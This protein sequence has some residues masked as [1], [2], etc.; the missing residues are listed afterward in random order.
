MQIFW[1][2]STGSKPLPVMT[3]SETRS[4]PFLT[5]GERRR[6]SSLLREFSF[7]EDTF[8]GG[9][10]IELKVPGLIGPSGTRYKPCG[11]QLAL[12]GG[13]EAIVHSAIGMQTPESSLAAYSRILGSAHAGDFSA[14]KRAVGILREAVGSDGVR[15]LSLVWPSVRKN[16]NLVP[17]VAEA[18][19]LPTARRDV[20]LKQLHQ[21]VTGELALTEALR[22]GRVPAA[23]Q[24]QRY[25][26]RSGRWAGGLREWYRFALCHE[27]SL[28]ER[29]AK[30]AVAA[31]IGALARGE[32]LKAYRI[33]LNSQLPASSWP[34]E[35]V[36]EIKK[37]SLLQRA[38]AQLERATALAYACLSS[39]F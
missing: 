25:L 22:E 32:Q 28:P 34:H 24:V 17:F 3:R 5:R 37:V 19:S 6:L 4:I 13:V 16:A 26:A 8:L 12:L 9:R 33:L 30:V 39:K 21:L 31:S 15:I 7:G 36:R 18:L 23:H 35:V 11:A 14:F 27:V 10:S 29:F 38:L 2:T 1:R 20:F